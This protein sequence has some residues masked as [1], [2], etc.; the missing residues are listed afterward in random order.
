MFHISNIIK[1]VDN[2]YGHHTYGTRLTYTVGSKAHQQGE[3]RSAEKTH[4]H[5]A[6]HLVLTLG[7]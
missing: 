6:R 3:H 1:K 5:Q 7:N 4:Y 2:A